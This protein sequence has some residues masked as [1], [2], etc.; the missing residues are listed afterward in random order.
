MRLESTTRRIDVQPP[1]G[2]WLGAVA[3]RPAASTGQER[4]VRRTAHR[5]F[6][7]T[8]SAWPP[9]PANERVS[10]EVGFARFGRGS[11]AARRNMS[12]TEI[13][14]VAWVDGTATT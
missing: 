3:D 13:G 8:S 12:T 6:E 4:E 5:C 1:V 14:A 10:H 11:N 9:L 2:R 7:R